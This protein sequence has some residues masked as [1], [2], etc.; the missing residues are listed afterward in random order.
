MHSSRLRYLAYLETTGGPFCI[1][2]IG[3]AAAWNTSEEEDDYWDLCDYLDHAQSTGLLF[4]HTGSADKEVYIFNAETA[5][6]LIF[7]GS[8]G[9]AVLEM[10]HCSETWSIPWHGLEFEV[11]SGNP[12]LA[13][14]VNLAGS[15]AIFDSALNGKNLHLKQEGI[16]K[17]FPDQ[18]FFDLAVLKLSKKVSTTRQVRYQSEEV[19][20]D[21]FQFVF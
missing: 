19:H 10:I 16:L 7:F 1:A 17:T 3:R 15:V 20:L 14:P 18:S 9:L 12:A 6:C 4:E 5:N 21:G 11:K 8:E 2:P 13:D